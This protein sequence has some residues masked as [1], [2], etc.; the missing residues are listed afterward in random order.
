MIGWCHHSS[1]WVS[2]SYSNAFVL[3]HK[4]V[5]NLVSIATPSTSCRCLRQSP[6]CYVY[7]FVLKKREPVSGCWK[8]KSWIDVFRLCSLVPY[9]TFQL[10]LA[11]FCFWLRYRF[12]HWNRQLLLRCVCCWCFWECSQVWFKSF[13]I[14]WFFFTSA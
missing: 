8:W 14:S 11:K 12:S 4:N 10:L 7:W 1:V 6:S 9:H 5:V 3:L 13:L 2:I